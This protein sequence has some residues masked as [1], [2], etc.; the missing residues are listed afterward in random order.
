MLSHPPSH[1]L[2]HHHRAHNSH[3]TNSASN[4][5]ATQITDIPQP[6]DN[7]DDV[8]LG[9]LQL[10]MTWSITAT[11]RATAVP[12]TTTRRTGALRAHSA[13]AIKTDDMSEIA[14]TA[15]FAQ[16]CI[17]MKK[18]SSLRRTSLPPSL[19][20]RPTTAQTK[21]SAETFSAISHRPS[22]HVA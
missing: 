16:A 20:P 12:A 17:I 14:H 19:Q 13:S 1:I 18:R 3:T 5:M 21:N 7:N 10:K 6:Y 15:P 4:K 11:P 22:S 9:S 2:P 8:A